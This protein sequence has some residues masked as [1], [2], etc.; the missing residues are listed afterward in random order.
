MKVTIFINIY[1][2]SIT[3]E[4]I[5]NKLSKIPIFHGGRLHKSPDN[6]YCWI[7]NT[8]FSDEFKNHYT[9]SHWNFIGDNI[10]KLFDVP[11]YVSI[12]ANNISVYPNYQ[13][14]NKTERVSKVKE[15]LF[16][17]SGD[18]ISTDLRFW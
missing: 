10:H 8:T 15:T 7:V 12:Y 14:K 9:Q 4:V 11:I 1:D 3:E 17:F 5:A 16:D 6:R 2:I 13:K 18:D